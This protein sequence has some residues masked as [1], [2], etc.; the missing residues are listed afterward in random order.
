MEEA[1]VNI[2]NLKFNR[3]EIVTDA[4]QELYGI[5]KLPMAETEVEFDVEGIPLQMINGFRRALTDEMVGYALDVESTD[6]DHALST[7]EFVLQEFIINRLSNIPLR[8]K[9]PPKIIETLVLYLDVTNDGTS[10]KKVYAGDLRISSGILTEQI[11]NP[12]FMLCRLNPGK[13]VVL[14]N[15]RIKSGY[16]RDHAKYM[17]GRRAMYEHLDIEQYSKDDMIKPGGKAVD[18]SGYKISCMVANPMKHRF[19]VTFPATGENLDE[20]RSLLI[21]ACINIKDRLKSVLLI[22]D[23]KNNMGG[24]SYTVVKLKGLEEGI[25]QIP[26]ETYTIGEI[27]KKYVYIL[28]PDIVIIGG[29]LIRHENKLEIK[30]TDTGDVTKL[31]VSAINYA[32][33]VISAM[34]KGF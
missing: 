16:G 29:K 6:Y 15:I 22:M 8:A 26:G 17:V 19:K 25:I 3:L 32:I 33:N 21:D 31:I 14:R 23:Q 24:M 7:D 11:F 10:V 20:V 13:R 18:E 27:I 5:K 28:N 34:Q 9:I 4:I 12:T 1:I 30:F 2:S